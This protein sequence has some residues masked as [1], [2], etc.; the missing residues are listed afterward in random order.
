MRVQQILHLHMNPYQ[1]FE[2]LTL[3]NWLHLWAPEKFMLIFVKF[4]EF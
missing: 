2:I 1:T 3:T 4:Y